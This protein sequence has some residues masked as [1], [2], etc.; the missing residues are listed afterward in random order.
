M[1][2]VYVFSFLLSKKTG[3]HEFWVRTKKN[4]QTFFCEIFFFFLKLKQNFLK[5]HIFIKKTKCNC[6]FMKFVYSEC[7][8]HSFDI[9]IV[10]VNEKS[11]IFP[12]SFCGK[13]K[14]FVFVNTAS[15]ATPIGTALYHKTIFK[16]YKVRKTSQI[17]LKTISICFE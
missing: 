4:L 16:H 7:F 11:W 14:I 10:H 5:N 3:K 17:S 12:K 8:Q 6:I 9:H 1:S 15:F 13:I 2:N